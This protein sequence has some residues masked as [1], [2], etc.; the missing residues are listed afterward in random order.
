MACAQ[1]RALSRASDGPCPCVWAL[2]L[3]LGHVQCGHHRTQSPAGLNS[4]T[5]PPEARDPANDQQ[6]PGERKGADKD[7]RAAAVSVAAA[8]AM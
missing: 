3:C 5:L 2:S 7:A 1:D 4:S 8:A 6:K